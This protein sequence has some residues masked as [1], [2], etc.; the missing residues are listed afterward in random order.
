MYLT[1]RGRAGARMVL[2]RVTRKNGLI[3][4]LDAGCT[5]LYI[6]QLETTTMV[7]Y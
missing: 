4:M 3:A 6:M 7:V 2:S 1:V 5:K